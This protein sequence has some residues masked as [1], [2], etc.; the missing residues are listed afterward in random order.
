MS[1]RPS[2]ERLEGR[3]LLSSFTVTN[4]LDSGPG[5]LRAAIDA[6]NASP[7]AD[8]IDIADGLKGT[9]SLTSPLSVTEDLTITG[10]GQAKLTV[11]GGSATRAMSVAGAETHLALRQLTIADGLASA[12]AGTAVGGGLLNDGASVSVDHVTFDG[13]RAVGHRAAG[14]AVANLGGTFLADHTDFVGNGVQCDDGQECFGG[15]VFNDHGAAVQIDHATFSNNTSAAGGAN[16]GAIDVVNGSVVNLDHCTFD[17]NEALGA[18]GN[19]AAG[20]AIHAIPTGLSGSSTPTLNVS[21]CSFTNNRSHIR[22]N[23]PAGPDASGQGFG[24]AIMIEF[25][26]TAVVEHST[27]DGNLAQGRSGGD[28]AAGANGRGG[29]P[30]WGGAINNISSNLV[31]SYSQFTDNRARGGDGGTGGSGAN[32]GAG[33]FG[34]GGA[35]ATG[36]LAPVITPP[37]TSVDHC[38]FLDNRAVGGDGGTGGTGGNGGAAGRADGGGIL[39]TNGPITIDD[40][41]IFGNAALGGVGGA[42]G[43]GATTR[44]GDGGLSRGGG[45][46]NERGSISS[47][48]GTSIAS[49]QASGGPGGVARAGG[50]ALG[51][52]VFN[53]RA[54]GIAP[55]PNAPSNLTMIECEVTDNLATG[56]T[57]GAGGNGGNASGGGIANANPAPPLPGA[58]LLT[59][60]SSLVT[61][62]S[63][64]GG[65]AGAGGAGGAGVGGGLFNQL[66]AFASV[67]AFS[68]ITGNHASSSNDDVFGSVTPI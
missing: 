58:P 22:A 16:G 67:D 1:N 66:T 41:S 40:S 53:G 60:M 4:L 42:A 63:A 51:G 26:P 36:T 23:V 28:G 50:E 3:R 9:I 31:V 54:S 48:T 56:G 8:S 12:P 47:V 34:I 24:G 11:S 57:G 10:S 18:P 43:T 25:G 6:A 13:N 2:I 52:G 7:G 55:D 68:I 49:N 62:N 30:A 38:Q 65:T 64:I 17:G 5:S 27:F 20:G 59:L 29:G 32:G 21:H 46:A 33:N 19:Y 37:V 15:A 35:I 45:F 39:N 44:G 61:G 14:G